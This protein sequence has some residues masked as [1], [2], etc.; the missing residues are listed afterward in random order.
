MKSYQSVIAL[1]ES[2][3]KPGD[4]KVEF[5]LTIN[6]INRLRCVDTYAFREAEQSPQRG[7]MGVVLLLNVPLYNVKRCAARV[8][9]KIRRR[10]KSI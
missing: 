1:V 8:T 9:S 10:P 7:L 6:T 5:M 4:S 3:I 2:G